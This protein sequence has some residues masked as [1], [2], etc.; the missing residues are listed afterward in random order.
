MRVSRETR[1]VLFRGLI[2]TELGTFPPSS[3]WTKKIILTAHMKFDYGDDSG[4]GTA[5]KCVHNDPGGPVRITA[6]LSSN[7][8]SLL[9]WSA[10]L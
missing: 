8:E 9:V 4:D 1:P 5:T 6:W 10:N 3:L 2:V 7:C